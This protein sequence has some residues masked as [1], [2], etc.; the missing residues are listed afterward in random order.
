MLTSDILSVLQWWFFIF[1]IGFGFLPLT[2]TVFSTFIDKGY[3]FSK[4][5]GIAA[6]SYTILFLGIFHIIPFTRIETFLVLIIFFCLIYYRF[7]PHAAKITRYHLLLFLFEELLFLGAIF[8]WSYI[9]SFSPDIHGLEKFM[10]YG[11]INSILRSD[12]FPPR[13]MWLTPH[14]I[15]YYYFGHLVTATLTKLTNIP[16]AISYN[17]MLATVFSTCFVG[18]FSIALNL[19]P[20]TKKYVLSYYPKIISAGIVVHC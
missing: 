18:S 5:L 15:N 7:L 17:L 4:I 20:L 9:R 6:I 1:V 12:Y 11:F 3:V 2:S 19:L 8:L 13:D 14:S 10:D 16:S